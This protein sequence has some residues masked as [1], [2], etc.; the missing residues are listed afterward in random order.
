MKSWWHRLMFRLRHRRYVVGWDP[1]SGN[2]MSCLQLWR[3]NDD[4][5]MTLMFMQREAG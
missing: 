5:T 4:G 1:A 2:D 3:R